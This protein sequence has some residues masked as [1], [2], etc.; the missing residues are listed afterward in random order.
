MRDISRT[1]LP[2]HKNCQA[3]LAWMVVFERGCFTVS[4]MGGLR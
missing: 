1:K 3:V 2:M 4:T